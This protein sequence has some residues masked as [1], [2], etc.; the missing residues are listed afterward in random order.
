MAPSNNPFFGFIPGSSHYPVRHIMLPITFGMAESYRT[1]YL[2][3][4]VAG[5]ESSYNAILGRPALAKFMAIP[6]HTYLVLKMP[7][8][9]S[10]L[11]IRGDVQTS[12]H[13]E[14]EVV[15]MATN[16]EVE[17]TKELVKSDDSVLPPKE[18][19]IPEKDKEDGG[20]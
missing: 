8:P 13:C 4:E 14:K 20:L 15:R 9:R 12:Y 6:N 16:Q 18:K 3:F 10:V 11:N 19:T 5:F 1:E 2:H 7:V 17:A